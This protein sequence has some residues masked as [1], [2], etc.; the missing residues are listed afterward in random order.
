VIPPEASVWGRRAG[1]SRL[2]AHF[3]S[4]A[5]MGGRLPRSVCLARNDIQRPALSW[6]GPTR[7]GASRRGRRSNLSPFV[8]KLAKYGTRA[9]RSVPAG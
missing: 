4:S 3:A 7:S 2:A 8:L 9:A 1:R 5:P 6:R